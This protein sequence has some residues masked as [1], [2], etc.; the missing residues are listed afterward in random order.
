V[1][2]WAAHEPLT[3]DLVWVSVRV[4]VL[5]KV[6]GILI[7]LSSK[8]GDSDPED[9]INFEDGQEDSAFCTLPLICNLFYINGLI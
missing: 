2:R 9:L 5:C 6:S 7:S 8:F 1:E 4:S 3:Y